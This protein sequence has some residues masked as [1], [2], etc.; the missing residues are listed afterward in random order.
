MGP[1]EKFRV[2]VSVIEKCKGKAHPR[3]D[4]EGTDG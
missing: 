3:T 4:H 2:G 1:E